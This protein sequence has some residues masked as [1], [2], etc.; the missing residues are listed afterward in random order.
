MSRLK[1]WGARPENALRRVLSDSILY[2][3]LLR[4]L[5]ESVE[6][7][8]LHLLIE[9]G[10]YAKAFQI[11]HELKGSSVY[12]SLI[13]LTE[14]LDTLTELLRPFYEENKVECP[15]QLKKKI[16]TALQEVEK[17][18]GRYLLALST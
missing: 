15:M 3:K 12:L 11:S 18:W 14:P 1:E 9:Q 5:A 4:D 13:P 6:P 7:D 2:E 16:D 10:A 17:E 8:M